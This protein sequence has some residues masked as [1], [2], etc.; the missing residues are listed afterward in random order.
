MGDTED[1]LPRC[2]HDLGLEDLLPWL[3][4]FV[5]KKV[6]NSSNGFARA[7]MTAS[8]ASLTF[9][10]ASLHA[11]LAASSAAASAIMS[12]AELLVLSLGSFAF[13]QLSGAGFSSLSLAFCLASLDNLV[14]SA[15]AA[16]SLQ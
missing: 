7:I 3:S 10:A 4:C 8:F 9:L 14:Y 2:L 5:R 15:F 12:G 11:F 13:F 16:S 1:I 6:R